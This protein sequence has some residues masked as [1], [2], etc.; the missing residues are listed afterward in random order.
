MKPTSIKLTLAGLL[1]LVAFSW[2][3]PLRADLWLE[4]AASGTNALL[5]W[6]NSAAT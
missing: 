1:A 4:I 5:T 6:T 2:G 3:L